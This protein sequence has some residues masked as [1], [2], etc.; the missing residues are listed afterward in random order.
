MGNP[1]LT[2]L[3]VGENLRTL[4]YSHLAPPIALN[5][6]LQGRL[7]NGNQLDSG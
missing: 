2:S 3:N 1:P 6:L 4:L 7:A 5:A